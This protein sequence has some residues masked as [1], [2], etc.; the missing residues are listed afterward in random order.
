M[1]LEMLNGSPATQEGAIER[2][3]RA[4]AR[5]RAQHA[6]GHDPQACGVPGAGA[7]SG[8]VRRIQQRRPRVDVRSS[9][10]KRYLVKE[11]TLRRAVGS[12]TAQTNRADL[13]CQPSPAPSDD[14]RARLV[15]DRRYRMVAQDKCSVARLPQVQGLSHATKIFR[16][17]PF[18]GT[19]AVKKWDQGT[20]GASHSPKKWEQGRRNAGSIVPKNEPLLDISMRAQGQW[21]P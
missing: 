2:P 16:R 10:G 19:K 18:F 14:V 7:A 11:H 15:P 12:L 1:R 8:A 20:R 17:P 3:I 21:R 5:E 9:E 13:S 6:G 4:L